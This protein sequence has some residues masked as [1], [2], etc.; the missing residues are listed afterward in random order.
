M[1]R[2]KVAPL[3]TLYVY[4]GPPSMAQKGARAELRAL[5][6]VARAA[7]PVC[8]AMNLLAT[9]STEDLERLRK[10]DARLERAGKEE[11]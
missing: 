11:R 6:A 5:L 7:R 2:K 8:R 3:L 4:H 1:A 10:A 9:I